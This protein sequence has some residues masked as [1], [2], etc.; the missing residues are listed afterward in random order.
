MYKASDGH[1]EI[2]AASIR[3]QE[4]FMQSLALGAGIITAPFSVLEAWGKAGMPLPGENY[5][6]DPGSLAAIPYKNLDLNQPWQSFNIHH[7][8][9]DKGIDG[10]TSDWNALLK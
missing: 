6:Y 1:T 4:H 9:T 8:L 3:S 5:T 2:L 10:F 7:E